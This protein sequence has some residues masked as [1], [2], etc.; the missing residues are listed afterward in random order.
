MPGKPARI[1]RSS[2]P[3]P[4]L[5]EGSC[6]AEQTFRATDFA[7]VPDP[8]LCRRRHSRTTTRCAS[9][10]PFLRCRHLQLTARA[11]ARNTGC[12][13]KRRRAGRPAR[14]WTRWRSL[15]PCAPAS[16]VVFRKG[17]HAALRPRPGEAV[18]ARR[19]VEPTVPM[20]TAP[21]TGRRP[22]PRPRTALAPRGGDGLRR[23]RNWLRGPACSSPTSAY[24]ARAAARPTGLAAAPRP[25]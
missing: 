20:P 18:S 6:G 11:R 1:G 15:E 5:S 8:H 13:S 12:L 14:S 9:C 24:L 7:C 23:R 4:H 21:P 3:G 19:S 22:R 10:L 25:R 16:A 17:Q 2:R